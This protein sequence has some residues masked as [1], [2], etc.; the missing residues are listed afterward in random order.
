MP[1]INESSLIKIKSPKYK[2]RRADEVQAEHRKHLNE[3]FT[4]L[5]KTHSQ[6][7]QYSEKRDT[8][9]SAQTNQMQ[10]KPFGSTM[11][12]ARR[13]TKSERRPM[14]AQKSDNLKSVM[15]SEKCVYTKG[16][17]K[18]AKFWLTKVTDQTKGI[19]FGNYMV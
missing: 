7:R 3:L 17:L 18:P 13:L 16:I 14:F 9:V 19:K 12:K 10:G 11:G 5:R 2:I 15:A 6:T 1:D 8:F 4:Q